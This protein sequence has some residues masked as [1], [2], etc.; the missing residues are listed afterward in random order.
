[1][2]IMI[3]VINVRSKKLLDCERIGVN[4][5]QKIEHYTVRVIFVQCM[6]NGYGVSEHNTVD[7]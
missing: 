2:V 1:M 6:C 7:V 3:S 4:W 5:A